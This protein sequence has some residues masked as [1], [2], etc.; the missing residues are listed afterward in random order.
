MA[1]ESSDVPSDEIGGPSGS[2]WPSRLALLATAGLLFGYAATH[3]YPAP[4]SRPAATP[5]GSDLPAPGS[6]TRVGRGPPG[7]RLLVGGPSPHLVDAATGESAALDVPAVGPHAP[8]RLVRAGRG[9]LAFVP[10]SSPGTAASARLLAYL[11]R[12]GSATVGLGAAETGIAARDGGVITVHHTA[13]G[14]V[15]AG[16][17]PDGARRW[18]RRTP[19]GV[20]P[21]GD[22]EYGLVVRQ[23]PDLA[24]PDQ[25]APLLLVDPPTGALRRQLA[26]RASTVL[27]SRDD[28]VA[29]LGPD[30]CPPDCAVR[31]TAL[32]SGATRT[33][34]ARSDRTP[35][36]GAF[37]PDG[38]LLALSFGGGGQPSGPTRYPD[39]LVSVIDI[40]S[41]AVTVVRGYGG[42][43]Y[44]P[45]WLDWSS[46][47]R[48]VVML[49]ASGGR[50]RVRVA[51]SRAGSADGFTMLPWAFLATRSL[52]VAP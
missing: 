42:G 25:V 19:V 8:A 47:G 14:S 23:V 44:P 17:G 45:T 24:G 9:V 15:L 3:R 27:A 35:L 22:T 33:V 16:F 31:V 26:P 38:R 49:A 20:E 11:V 29:W 5:A 4:A 37:S 2:R 6:G 52:A 48:L 7:L 1:A 39:G 40:G 30:S 41:L 13:A 46:D 36:A 18:Q 50:E 32:A 34:L 10:P 43:L 12:P 21:L 51:V 28:A